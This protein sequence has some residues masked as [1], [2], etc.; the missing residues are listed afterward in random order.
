MAWKVEQG[1]SVALLATETSAGVVA[2][3]GGDRDRR[4]GGGIVRRGISN[5]SA[6]KEVLARQVSDLAD[7][8]PR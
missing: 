4:H 1:Y 8:H 2:S 7:P 6:L 5:I 3:A